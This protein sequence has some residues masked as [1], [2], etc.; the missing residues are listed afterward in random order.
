MWRVAAVVLILLAGCTPRA[1][2]IPA[3]EG[4]EAPGAEIRRVYVGTTRARDAAG[5]FGAERADTLSYG[6][7]DISVPPMREAGSVVWPDGPPDPQTDFLV[8]DS[9][10]LSG[11]SAFRADLTRALQER[12]PNA[13]EAVIYV[14]GFNNRFADGILRIAQLSRDF[15]LPGVAVHY[16]WPSAGT[17]LG[18]VYDRDSAMIARSGLATLIAETRAAGARRIIL[19]AHSMG[20][21]LAMEAMREMALA[22]PGSVARDIEAVLLISPDIDIEVFRSQARQIG[23]LPRYFGIFVSKRDRA[24]RLSARITGRSERLGNVGS[25]DRVADLDVTVFD[26]TDFSRGV[27]HFT[28]ATSPAV[29][30]IFANMRGLDTAFQTDSSGQAGL[31]PGTVITIQNATE[32]ILS[33]VAGITQALEGQ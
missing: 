25:V 4:A 24:L 21:M 12:P 29:I 2:L 27:G 18:Y 8:A 32:I 31:L 13:R 30:Q 15:D 20:G 22:R 5:R 9:L 33:P 6:R 19:V 3:P 1:A 23:A 16:S 26:L 11:P 7:L 28:A 17:P 14:H 10:A